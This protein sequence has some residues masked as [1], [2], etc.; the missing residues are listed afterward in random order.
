[1]RC[2]LIDVSLTIQFLKELYLSHCLKSIPLWL[3]QNAVDF[4]R[5]LQV[6]IRGSTICSTT[7]HL[8]VILGSSWIYLNELSSPLELSVFLGQFYKKVPVKLT[9]H[10]SLENCLTCF[11]ADSCCFTI[12]VF[13]NSITSSLIF[14]WPRLS[15]IFSVSF[16]NFSLATLMLIN[17]QSGKYS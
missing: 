3:Y 9:L 16:Q 10:R 14:N 12:G 11:I 1:M 2:C 6:E 5:W 17:I 7:C 15:L 8:L 4:S 13:P